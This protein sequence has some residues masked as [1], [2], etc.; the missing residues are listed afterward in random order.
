M[1]GAWAIADHRWPFRFRDLQCGVGNGRTVLWTSI[2]EAHGSIA[3]RDRA[4]YSLRAG[5]QRGRQCLP[6]HTPMNLVAL[7]QFPNRQ[8]LNTAVAPDLL[9]ELHSCTHLTDL[10]VDDTDVKI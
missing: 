4:T 1:S 8:G 10:H 6:H 3:G 7:G 9:E 2:T 5:R